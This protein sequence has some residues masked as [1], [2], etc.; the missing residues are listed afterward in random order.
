[1]AKRKRSARKAAKF[2]EAGYVRR[3]IG[4]IL[5]E[6][7][8]RKAT[9]P[10][11]RRA[12]EIMRGE[13]EKLGLA[14]EFKPFKFNDSLYANMALH[15]GMAVVGTVVS[16]VLPA[17]GLALHAISSGSYWA[18]AS[19]RGY[20][21]RRL[22]GFKDAANLLAVAPSKGRPRVRIVIVSHADAGFT[23]W[24][25]D[26]RWVRLVG[27]TAS[28][29][30]LM[31]RPVSLATKATAALTFFDALRMAFG[32]AT[33]PLRPLEYA[34]TVPALLTFLINA[35][36]L[37]H[38]TI[39][40]GAN[41]N[42]GSVA[43]LPILARRLLPVKPDDVELVFV[44]SAC[45]EAS[46]GGADA[47]SRQMEN[48]WDKSA[49]V[50]LALDSIANGDLTYIKSEGEVAYG[51]IEPWLKETI[52]KTAGEIEGFGEIHGFEPPV[53]GTDAWPF[54][55]H[56]WK[57]AGFVCIDPELGMPRRY[58]RPDDTLENLEIDGLLRSINFIEAL[59]K[60]VS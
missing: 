34:L 42:L 56:G 11:E 36:I 2:D 60:N 43:A 58:H 35:Q 28:G 41:D 9:S 50:V 21:L 23:G 5:E 10:A 51:E 26:P 7:P 46:L 57:A 12:Q 55:A 22:L 49:T 27:P 44:V 37:I 59:V 32:P 1:M 45:E 52:E 40:P 15:F 19:R 3:L 17:A 39:V 38:N 6:C 16:G 54:M 30:G 53:G 25:F 29:D 47:L 8:Q 18:D 20:L 31:S 48:V 24:T 14:T 4:T 13:F 33:L